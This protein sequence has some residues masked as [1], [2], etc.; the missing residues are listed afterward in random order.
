VDAAAAAFGIALPE[1]EPELD[2]E[3]WKENW[4]V[5]GL[6]VRIGTQWRTSVGGVT[7][8]DYSAVIAVINMYAYPEPQSLLEDLQVMEIAAMEEMNKEKK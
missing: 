1:P 8:L 5:V 7:G 2:F 6:F 3:V 4:D